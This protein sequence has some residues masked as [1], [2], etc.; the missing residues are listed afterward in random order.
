MVNSV[1]IITSRGGGS[2]NVGSPVVG[3]GMFITG[4][5][6]GSVIV[7]NPV[8]GGDMMITGGTSGT[9]SGAIII[10]SPMVKSNMTTS[11]GDSATLHVSASTVGGNLQANGGSKSIVIIGSVSVDGNFTATTGSG[12]AVSIGTVTN[13]GDLTASTGDDST[14]S[15]GS[16][17]TVGNLTATAGSESSLEIGSGT[18]GGNLTA[19]AGSNSSIEIGI[20]T[21]D[22]NL[23]CTNSGSTALDISGAQV[24]GDTTLVVGDATTVA[25]AT[26]DGNTSVTLSNGPAMLQAVLPTGTFT[27]NVVFSVDSLAPASVT[28]SGGPTNGDTFSVTTVAAY[29]FAFA[30]PTLNQDAALTF[31]IQLAALD[32]ASRNA[33]LTALAAGNASVG[34]L[35]DAPGSTWQTFPICAANESPTPGGCVSLAFLDATGTPLPP[36]ST[37]APAVVRFTGLAGHF[38][39]YGVVMKQPVQLATSRASG[40][41]LRLTWR[42][43]ASGILETSTNLAPNSWSP[44]GLPA[45]QSDG[46]WQLDVAP[47]EPARFYRFRSP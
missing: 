44:A 30:I 43:P 40:G 3:N 2:V 20:V 4:S 29:R 32:A 17:S 1:M 13:G 34:V 46:S 25:A 26:A 36:D 7:G 15:I 31:D 39:T 35:G 24:S 12:G 28:A 14:V 47:T 38:S 33:F 6:S 9:N 27:T 10:Q 11:V 37:N 21:V 45:Q 18:V 19:S 23:F 41:A 5:G 42:G 16:V 22:G 8:V